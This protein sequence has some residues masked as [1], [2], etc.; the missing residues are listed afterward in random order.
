MMEDRREK[1]IRVAYA[2]SR[3]SNSKIAHA[4]LILSSDYCL[5]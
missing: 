5:L 4:A 2:K 1:N 3:S